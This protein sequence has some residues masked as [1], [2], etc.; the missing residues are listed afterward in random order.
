MS[1]LYGGYRNKDPVAFKGS[2]M[3]PITILTK[4]VTT[5]KHYNLPCLSP[6]ILKQII[7]EDFCEVN[8]R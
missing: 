5:S 4:T 3:I 8:T 7:K 1:W 6:T 2:F